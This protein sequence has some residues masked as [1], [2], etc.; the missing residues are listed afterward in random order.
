MAKNKKQ[1]LNT[2]YQNHLDF[3][4]ASGLILIGLAVFGI[5]IVTLLIERELGGELIFPI[6]AFCVFSAIAGIIIAVIASMKQSVAD[7]INDNLYAI[8]KYKPQTIYTFYRKMCRYEKKTTFFNFLLGAVVVCVIGLIMLANPASVSLG[9]VFLV[10]SGL[11]LL[12]GIYFLPYVQY[13]FLMLRTQIMGDAKEIIFSRSG[14]WYCGKVCYFG[15]NGI[16]YH[17]VER[18]ETHGF[19]TIVFY[20]TLTRGFQQTAKELVIPVSPKMAYAA[21]DLVAE[22]NRSDLLSQEKYKKRR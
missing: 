9:I 14:I 6:F 13:L 11:L 5:L 10:F 7:D 21:D 1:K 22:F 16:T 18:R 8:W 4:K 19:D 17:R 12:A 20:Y 15:R 3:L 2:A